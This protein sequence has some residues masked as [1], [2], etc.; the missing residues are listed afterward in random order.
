MKN[1]L[2]ITSVPPSNA[3]T[4]SDHVNALLSQSRFNVKQIDLQHPEMSHEITRTDCIILH[5]S[6]VAFPYRGGVSLN[7]LTRLQ[8]SRSGKP[9]VH[10]VQD[11]QRNVLERFRYFESLGVDHVFSVASKGVYDLMYPPDIRSF[12]VSTLLTGYTPINLEDFQ[13]K[14]WDKRHIDI[15]YRA[16]K[17]PDWYGNLGTVKG[18]ISNKLNNLSSDFGFK[19]DA[20]CKEE[21]R[22]YGKRWIDFLCN[23]K[24]AVGTESGSSTLDFDGRYS[25][26]EISLSDD[27]RYEVKTPVSA[28]YSALS[29][30]IFE[31]A[32]AKCLLALTP[33]EYSGALIPGV[34]YFELLPNLSNIKQLQELMNDESQRRQLIENAYDHLIVSKKFGHEH[35]VREVDDCLNRLFSTYNP[36]VVYDN[37]NTNGH[38]IGKLEKGI[39]VPRTK[40]MLRTPK[41]IFNFCARFMHQWALNRTGKSRLVIRALMRRLFKIYNSRFFGFFKGNSIWSSIRGIE[42]KQTF[43]ITRRIIKSLTLLED[44]NLIKFEAEQLLSHGDTLSLNETNSGIWISWPGALEQTNYLKKHPYLDAFLFPNS[45]GV[46]LTRSDFSEIGEPRRLNSLSKYY[47]SNKKKTIQLIHLFCTVRSA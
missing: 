5:Y 39:Q 3:T 33:G 34:H 47:K 25:G 38:K 9:I 8:I 15:S 44:L 22:L 10:M 35:M 32:A 24:V 18:D 4:I 17:L 21:D 13:N 2:L 42:F 43:Q 37:R 31:Y 11:E 1:V 40:V 27:I 7:S 19:I 28:N 36:I 16:R 46:W 6:V 12:T 45:S 30:R 23:S 41:E 20:S 14:D 29:P 26:L